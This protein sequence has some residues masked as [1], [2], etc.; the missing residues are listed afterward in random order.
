MGKL[1]SL[2]LLGGAVYI[3]W[4][5]L[6]RSS[7]SVSTPAFQFRVG[8]VPYPSQNQ[9]PVDDSIAFIPGGAVRGGGCGCGG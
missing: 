6:S 7:A 9:T 8:S 3:A 1:V 5:F 4:R 2:V